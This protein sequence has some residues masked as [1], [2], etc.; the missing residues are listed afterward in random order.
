MPFKPRKKPPV[1]PT[2]TQQA[3]ED[4]IDPKEKLTHGVVTIMNIYESE[5]P[6]PKD[7]RIKELRVIRSEVVFLPDE[8]VEHVLV[9]RHPVI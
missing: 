9:V 3:Q 8:D 5:F 7:T 4:R 1:I 2:R 6:F